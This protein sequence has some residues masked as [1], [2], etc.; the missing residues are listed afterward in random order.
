[1]VANIIY[2]TASIDISQISNCLKNWLEQCLNESGQVWLE[3]AIQSL[4]TATSEQ[5]LFTNFSL[6]PRRIGKQDLMLTSQDLQVAHQLRQGW[7]PD[8]WSI[9]QAA[10]TLLLLSFPSADGDR[11]V[12][13]MEKLFSA[14]DVAEQ[15]ALYQTLP[16]FPHAER[17]LD[18]AIDGL[19]T[20]INAVFNA[21]A[22]HNPYPAEYFNE[23]AWNQMVLKAI[24]IGSPLSHIKGLDDRA[25]PKLAR[26]LSDYVHERWA[27]GR[28]ANPEIWRCVGPFAID[29]FIPDLARVIASGEPVEQEAGMLALSKAPQTSNTKDL[30]A[31]QPDIL[32]RIESDDLNWNSFVDHWLLE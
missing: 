20:N 9:D 13:A 19:R 27:A 18:R 16:L 32:T 8:H 11:Y 5:S 22:L 15:V 7:T 1:M 14:A 10:R 29:E 24:F 17:F 12:A 30:L 25:N 21:I 6:A 4:S 2:T 26:M 31:T 28:S 23:D 3:K